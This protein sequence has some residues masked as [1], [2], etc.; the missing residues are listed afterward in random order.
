MNGMRGAIYLPST[1][2]LREVNGSNKQTAPATL[3]AGSRYL[4]SVSEFEV[5]PSSDDTGIIADE[6]GRVAE[7]QIFNAPRHG[8]VDLAF[9]THPTHE[10]GVGFRYS[11]TPEGATDVG[12]RVAEVDAGR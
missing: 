10:T 2:Q 8:L 7:V 6:V 11:H 4:T 1:S 12:L 9:D 5:E 3:R